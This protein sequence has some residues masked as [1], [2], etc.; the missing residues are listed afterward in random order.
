MS[1]CHECA[2]KGDIPGDAHISCQF[3]WKGPTPQGDLHGV[4]NGWYYFPFNYD[5]TWMIEEC[6]NFATERDESR[7]AKQ[8]PHDLLATLLRF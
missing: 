7:V 3:D 4:R 5:P 8:N 1:K 6:P 2:Y